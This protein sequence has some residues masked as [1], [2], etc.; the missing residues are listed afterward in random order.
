VN[1]PLAVVIAVAAPVTF[2]AS[3]VIEQRAT[4]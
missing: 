2:A 1:V 3:D 4:K